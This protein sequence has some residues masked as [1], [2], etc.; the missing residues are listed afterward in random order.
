MWRKKGTAK[1]LKHTASS[2]NH[3][4]GGVMAWA[5]MAASGTGPLKFTNDLMYADSRAETT[6]R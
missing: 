2:V 6:N 1:D 5:C 3:D 4:G